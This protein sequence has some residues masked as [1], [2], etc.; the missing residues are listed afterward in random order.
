VIPSNYVGQEAV[1][2]QSVD[3]YLATCFCICSWAL[4]LSAFDGFMFMHFV[5]FRIFRCS[6]L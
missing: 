5:V 1:S 3:L 2:S 4:I 6:V